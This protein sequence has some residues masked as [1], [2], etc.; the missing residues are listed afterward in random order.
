M[1][2]AVT[3]CSGQ[4]FNVSPVD[5]G[6]TTPIVPAGTSYTW[7]VAA[8]PDITGESNQAA[9]QGSIGQTLT[10]TTNSA[11]TIRYTVTPTAGAAVGSCVGSTF[12]V[13]V[14]VNPTPVIANRTAAICSG[15]AFN[16]APVNGTP[17]G[18]IVP[19]GTT[20]SWPAPVVTG[21]IT[22]GSAATG[23]AAVN[24][25]LTNPSTSPQTATY[26]VTPTSGAAGSCV[27]ANFTVT[28]TVNPI[29]TLSS[30]LTPSGI[31]SGTFSYTP[32]SLTGGATFAWTRANIPGISES[33][34][35]GTGNI[36][37]T[38]TNTTTSF[39][40]VTYVVTTTANSCPNTGQNV[41]VRVNPTPLGN[42]ILG[43]SNVC[44]GTNPFFYSVT[45]HAGATY[46]WDIP[47]IF[48]V[49]AAGGGATPGGGF[50]AFTADYFIL[51]KF[52]TATPPGG[53]AIRVREKSADGC[54]GPINTLT[55]VAA[56]SPPTVPIAGGNTFCKFEKGVV[57]SVPQNAS[58][59][60]TW[61]INSGG[62]I[63]GPSAGTNL[64]QIIVDFNSLSSAQI[65]V[66]ETNI[67]GCPASYPSLIVSLLDAPVTAP[68]SQSICSG[69]QP[70]S[71]VDLNA[72]TSVP[73]SFDWYVKSISAGVTGAVLN[74]TGTGALE[75][76]PPLQN[77]SG[78]N[79]T[80]VYSVTPTATSSPFCIG[81]P[82]D[83]T[84]TVKPE[85]VVGAIAN[86]TLC[87][88]TFVNS[89]VSF[90]LTSNVGGST[91]NWT[92]SN[93][94]IGLA[95]AS[96][97]GNFSFT[98]ADNQTG[99]D[100]VST[101]TVSATAAGCTSTG[102]N[103]KTFTITVR[104]RPVINAIT[105][106]TVCPGDAVAVPA[107]ASNTGGSETYAW[108]NDNTAIG[109][110]T[111]GSGNIAGYFAPANNTGSDV[112]G[113]IS[114][115]ATRNGC[116]GPA[117]TFKITIKPQPVVT[118]VTDKSFC[119]GEAISIPLT[120]NVGGAA[121][122]WSNSNTSIGLAASGSGNITGTAPANNTG[123][124]IVG[125]ITVS[126]VAN[127]CTSAGANVKTFTITIKPTP[128]VNDVT[129]VVVCSGANIPTQ[130]FSSNIASG[131]VTFAWTNTN[132]AI[133]LAASGSG[134]ITAFTAATNT[135]GTPMVA[136]ISVVG[137]KN[138]C[139]GPA[140]VFTITV[141][142]EPIVTA[143]TNVEACPGD[144]VAVALT[145]NVG[146]ATLNWTNSNALIGLGTSGT[147]NISFTAPAN[148]TGTN[149]DAT[150]SVT[151]TANGCTSTGTNSKT[152]TIRIKPTP[153]VNTVTDVT[154]CS[155][156]AISTI[157]F[158]ANTGGSETFS[159]T[160]DN[161]SIGLVASGTGNITGYTA[162][163]NVSGT[164]IVA[165]ITVSATRLSCAG[166]SKTFKITVNPE[167]VVT[168]ITNKSF[169]PTDGVNIP[170]TSNVAGATISWTNSN[171][172]IGIGASGTG[173]I[174]YVA[175]AN[176]TGADI[177]GTITVIATKD[178]CVSSGAN[179]KSFTITIKA[180]P[181][182][183]AISN[184]TVCSGS[185]I[186]VP[187]F[188]SNIGSGGVTFNW[189]NDNT[190]I[191]LGASGSGNITAFAAASNTTSSS[192]VATISVTG[193]KN[194]CSGPAK[195]FTITVLPEPVGTSTGIAICSDA[196]VGVNLSTLITGGAAANRYNIA[197]T[198]A[199]ALTAT[200][201]SPVDGNNLTATE[202]QDDKWRNYTGT[203]AN[204]VYHITPISGGSPA[205]TGATFDLTVTI[206]PEPV[207]TAITNKEF[208]PGDVVNIP[209]LS[210]VAGATM[211]W[212]NSNGSIGLATSGTGDISFTAPAN[213]TGANIDGT[214]T[215]SGTAN[216]CTSTG[217]NIKTFSIRIKP[218]PIVN[219]VADVAVCSGGSVPTIA[220]TANTGGG[221]TFSW[222]NDNAGVGLAVSGTGTILGY[223]APVNISG[224]PIVAN[225]TVS[226][227][228]LS[229]PGP[230]KTFKITI[231]PEPVV[232]AIADKSFCPTESV[233]IPFTSNVAGATISWSNSNTLIGLGASGTGDVVFVAPA[234][235]TGSD[236]TG[237]ITVTATKDGCV[238]TGAN[239]KSFLITIKATPIVN[240]ISNITICSG[241]TI[242]VPAFGSNI[243][244]GGVTFNWTN[245][246][247]AIGL[248]ASGSGNIT[249]FAAAA[250]TTSSP[251]VA[252]IA[253]TGTKNL[254]SGPART[255]TITVLPE[256][257][258]TPT[259]VD[260]CSDAAV[261]VNLS[262]L[263]T[264]GAA[265]S[266][267]NIT[268]TNASGLSASAGAP[269]DGTNF[270]ATEI[271][272]D[273]WTNHTGTPHDIVYHITPISGGS[274]ACS[275][276]TFDLTVTIN[277]EP[278]VNVVAN[279]A[280]CPAESVNIPLASNVV[281]ANMSWTNSNP[282]IGLALTGTGDIVY[283]APAN[284]TGAAITATIT[285][286]AELDGCTSAGANT[287]QFDITIKPTPIVNTISD[288][289][290]CSGASIAAINFAANT[291][292]GETFAWTND[293]V[294]IGLPASGS[295]NIAAYTA[296]INVSGVP[297]V[298]NI[299]VTAT[300]LS[301]IGPVRNFQIIVNPEP[302]VTAI[303]DKSF[304][305]G[306]AVNIPFTSNV[307]SATISWTNDNT[308]IGIGTSGGGDIVYV[309]PANNTG[310]DIV[311]NIVVTATR[312]G[313]VSAGA[314]AKTFKITI[315]P[316]PIVNAVTNVTVC[317]GGPISAITFGSNVAAGGVTFDWTNDNTAVGLAAS[318]TGDIAA[319]TAGLNLTSTPMTAIVSVVGTK[320]G[321]SGPARTFNITVLPQP[322]GTPTTVTVCSDAAVAVNLNSLISG[323]A[324]KYD[325]TITNTAGLPASAG[326]P[327][328][329]TNA[330]A[331]EIQD[332]RWTNTTG[333]VQD[334]VYHI[335]PTGPGSPGCVG[336]SFDLTVHVNP[337]PVVTAVLNQEFCPGASVNIPLASNVLGATITWT[338]TN[339]V[340]G[341]GT[342]GSGNIVYTAPANNTGADI[343]GTITVNASLNGCMSSGSNTK[344]F[345]IKIKPTPIVNTITN[346]V[347]CSGAAI[348]TINF[349]ANTAGGE[350]FSWTNDNTAIGLPATGTN[351]IPGYT[352]PVNLSGA[353]I[354][355]TI[356]VSALRNGCPGPVR[357]F[358]ITVNP[359]P[360]VAAIPAQ[361]FCAGESVNIPLTSNVS[362]AAISWTNSNSSIGIGTAGSG[363]IIYTAP[364]NNTGSDIVGTIV[365]TAAKDGCTS[366]GAN[367]KTFTI[368]I[369]PTPIVSPVA[370]ITVCSGQTVNVPAFASNVVA[371]GVTFDWTND[372]TAIGLV[373]A[374]TGNITSF[375]AATNITGSAMT[376]NITVTGTKNS[377]S[378]PSVSFRIII[379][380]EPVVTAITDKEFCPGAIVNIP[381]TSNVP[382]ALI[383]WTNSNT[384]IG[385]GATGTG[386]IVYTAPTNTTGS[387]FVATIT[388]T[389]ERNTCISAGANAKTFQIRI[390]AAPVV[391]SIT[392]INV[393]SGDMVGPINFTSNADPGV[394]FDWTNDNTSINLGASGTGNIPGFAAAVNTSG[395]PL[396][397][398]IKV[399]GSKNGCTGVDATFVITVFPEPVLGTT[400]NAPIC[401]R[402]NTNITL[403]TNGTS[404]GAQSY[405]IDQIEYSSNGGPFGTA[406]P[407]GFTFPVTNKLVGASGLPDLI[408]N[409]VFTNLSAFVVTV[410]YTITPISASNAASP[411]GCAGDASQITIDVTPEPDLDNAP[412]PT[413][414]ICS[415]ET[416]VGA[417]PGF[418]LKTSAGSVAAT[419]FIIQA[420]NPHGLTPGPLN[421]TTG[422]GKPANAIND[423]SWINTG[424]T[425]VE[426]EYE[427]LPVNGSCIGQMEVVT[428][429]VNPAPAVKDGLDRI[430]CDGVISGIVLQDNFPG[431]IAAANYDITSI[432]VPAGL[433]PAG[434]NATTG[435]TT[436]IN[437]IRDDR[438][439]NTTTERIVV[440]Y[441]V[442]PVSSA[443]C[444]GPVKVITLMV[445]P[446]VVSATVNATPT[447]CSGD[448]V[449]LTFAS[450]TYSNG[451]PTNP[452]VT[453]SYTTLPSSISGATVGNNLS[454]GS[455]ITDVLVNTTNSPITVHYRITPRAAAASN[456]IG[457]PGTVED[458]AVIVEPKPR[459]NAIANKTVCEGV[460][461]NLALTST[462]A[463]STGS[464]KIFVTSTADP[465]ITGA[466]NNV[467]FANGTMITDALAN[468]A[469]VTKF[470]TYHLEVRN[471]DAAN[472]T[473]C[474]AGPPIDVV[475]GVTPTPVFTPI[476]NF[477]ICSGESFNPIP[478]NTDTETATP[479]S[480][481][482]TWTATP[483]PN[484]SGES[485]G[486]GNAFSQVLF[487][488]TNNKQVVLYTINATN[489][490]NT[491]S[492]V[493]TGM[494]LQ[495]TVYPNPRVVGLPSS[496]NVCNNGELTSD[497]SPYVLT[498]STLPALGTTFDWVVDN[499]ANPDMPVIPS[500][501]NQTAIDQVFVNNGASLG[502]QQ[503]SITA[504]LTIPAGDNPII[505]V[506]LGTDNVCTAQAD[507]VI[508]VNVAPP[509]NGDIFAYDIEG[510]VATE[511]YLCR[512][513]TQF[514]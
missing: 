290:V 74:Q 363:D 204:I 304:C 6:A 292:G 391:A 14:T 57:F 19:S 104:P 211:N 276:A 229:C 239:T 131:G 48:T 463:P 108:T 481:L 85:P 155:G 399:H 113:N 116:A 345:D 162:P 41:V 141:N 100:I 50:G 35:S 506:G 236:I 132:P 63:I 383:S 462:T 13:D 241:G 300:R 284:N 314:N 484:V 54:I 279:Q 173:D 252:T 291:G 440:S 21:G 333:T 117:R 414:A 464:I 26:T 53:L 43:P 11:V 34:S 349:S 296:P 389:A 212:T 331:S 165:N 439:T 203:S 31:C 171:T 209:L 286:T 225:I 311:G 254:C 178:G 451:N 231:N 123:A 500:A 200:A 101:I 471:V 335:I 247:T 468:S 52:S 227:S 146:G 368:T 396:I 51:L 348:S 435:V 134:N 38:L 339:T 121:I 181:I 479:G 106:I 465:E 107:F 376:A 489:I 410:R 419:S 137:T 393:C 126:A 127:S 401:S 167:P 30:T 354:I 187:N 325:I 344:T 342:S 477:A 91:I 46:S 274:P 192:V 405:R 120:S 268:I 176:N 458:V 238:S 105:D 99:V 233:N 454:E 434:T 17:A 387:D 180:T 323:A 380:P 133:N 3:I 494:P 251:V 83:I 367:T 20:Y 332:D 398:N 473:I 232:T 301:C 66:T 504:H 260:V 64:Y 109:L 427:V 298:A 244:S 191:G 267:F 22:G 186:T 466:S 115:V 88:N 23:Q 119:A 386:D 86:Q 359:E 422:T 18:T 188:A 58:S 499:G 275:G 174:V 270:T 493:A 55:I 306:E 138:G 388:V 61:S 184:I 258:G 195:T 240:A 135:S 122:N 347:V 124:D 269:V 246:N 215:V 327:V 287:K 118:A 1:D 392:S 154:V 140:E 350:T 497:G 293:N 4:A 336:T 160:N 248:V 102:A 68:T 478:I 253:V 69:S 90:P 460:P 45:Q 324:A 381:L 89:A 265:A 70:S 288:V 498:P 139:A 210:N 149:I 285:V 400:P 513:A 79:G 407:A 67:T 360:V 289:V 179:S 472:A 358:T 7:T 226:A 207:V 299:A 224:T 444:R 183:T 15:T 230:S 39:V 320:N 455:Q 98:T 62:T 198:N 482:I 356:G 456:G 406:A 263:I 384:S 110:A 338:N 235:N 365:V 302:V 193:T 95:A 437:R 78:A 318:G 317:S 245:D 425:F 228:K 202:I 96:G 185:M 483:N 369:K 495:V 136:T 421:E 5:G 47:S 111:S 379:N 243:G 443:G 397:A 25:T 364:S 194:S 92:S 44:V 448:A 438:F 341:L 351:N 93:P 150:I 469:S 330:T 249:S 412:N 97:T 84:I 213:N 72:I 130:T 196:A 372:N 418:F 511:V 217:A 474:S 357:T 420:I 221:E 340:I 486:A 476:A 36:S 488:N 206:N 505:D 56:N 170:F 480:T 312:N 283:T 266:R 502:T 450:P 352:A 199:A 395:A 378:G 430:V 501:T 163:V 143:I 147:G 415:G 408:K 461:V 237:T 449:D 161:T 29:P 390:K 42:A 264:G 503:Y 313:C 310:A 496:A 40:D 272:N 234:N 442:V 453:F 256:P 9:P 271:Q 148:N 328:N 142:P 87:P 452:V 220:F 197:I 432:N 507:A 2:Q 175:P 242:N 441:S 114:V 218:T 280:F 125:T 382:G 37:E 429:R 492:C 322:V 431:S 169:C 94:A 409:D 423:D 445:E 205:C 255:F 257:V 214:V 103:V 308:A 446:P 28:V 315:K 353:P 329:V 75:H 278:V 151:A 337:E 416:V 294:A 413:S 65:D 216:G 223:T 377:C 77:I 261:G 417:N 436:D 128:I 49:E 222:T 426:V 158:A 404:I 24:Q 157:V 321:C 201:G 159:W 491:P 82:V 59:T 259:T 164:P 366:A 457:C 262:T 297:I 80:I 76:F 411:T 295:S 485:N 12:F 370:D 168:A 305:P 153:I 182:V 303:T 177:V 309:A 467:L 319:F 33:A 362:G 490:S 152:F 508:V 374:G 172:A 129:D 219:T 402:V 371:A 10:N 509:V 334:I 346:V 8:S 273:K 81:V 428:V 470:V 73:S 71:V 208:C 373:G 32:T 112:I 514:I 343:L 394:T 277:P 375:T 250:N 361:L 512:G 385:I 282:A 189:T 403:A 144:P 475:V 326:S 16:I 355:A 60:F 424:N 145:S 459:I 166:P 156:G 27:G 510:N 447:I 487:N 433:T 316:T 190:A 281:G 307:A